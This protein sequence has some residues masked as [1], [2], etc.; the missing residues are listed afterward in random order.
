MTIGP[1]TPARRGTTSPAGLHIRELDRDALQR[2]V[3]CG[4]DPHEIAVDREDA[5]LEQRDRFDDHGPS[6]WAA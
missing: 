1:H 3:L 4:M 5:Q 2:D 6:R